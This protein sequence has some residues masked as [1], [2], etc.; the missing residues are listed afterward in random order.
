MAENLSLVDLHKPIKNVNF[1]LKILPNQHL[2]IMVSPNVLKLHVSRLNPQFDADVPTAQHRRCRKCRARA[3]KPVQHRVAR[4]GKR[5]YEGFGDA[6]RLLCR[7]QLVARVRPSRTSGKRA[8][9]K[10]GRP[11]TSR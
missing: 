1:R 10:G 8:A 11:L 7:V 9:G 2:E 6:C 4:L 3:S 5:L